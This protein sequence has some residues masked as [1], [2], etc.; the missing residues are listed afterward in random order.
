MPHNLNYGGSVLTTYEFHSKVLD[1]LKDSSTDTHSVGISLRKD[2]NSLYY[3]VVLKDNELLVANKRI[4]QLEAEIKL[5]KEIVD[6][7][8]VM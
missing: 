7:T 3:W 5:L 6:G 8:H 4:M 2:Y 1:L